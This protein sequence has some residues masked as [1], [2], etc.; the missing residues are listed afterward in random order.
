[1]EKFHSSKTLLKLAGRVEIGYLAGGGMYP[2][3]PLALVHTL[4]A[5]LLG[6]I[7]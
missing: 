1:M 7:M 4:Q 5:C 6:K 2:P 3:H